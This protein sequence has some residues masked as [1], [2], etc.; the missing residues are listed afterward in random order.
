[1]FKRNAMPEQNYFQKQ[2]MGNSSDNRAV[3]GRNIPT[4]RIQYSSIYKRVFNLCVRFNLEYQLYY[5]LIRLVRTKAW[6]LSFFFFQAKCSRKKF[7]V[8]NVISQTEQCIN[9]I[10]AETFFFAVHPFY[11]IR[12]SI[13]RQSIKP[14]GTVHVLCEYPEIFLL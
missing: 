9:T 2:E 10:V 5:S 3:A 4:R 1:M 6:P 13:F 8:Q 7:Q 11:E 12:Q 14:L